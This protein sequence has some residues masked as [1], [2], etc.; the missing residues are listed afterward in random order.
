MFL[1]A[2]A[3][4]ARSAVRSACTVCEASMD[5][6]SASASWRRVASPARLSAEA[7]W[8]RAS[9]YWLWRS[10]CCA[11]SI[12]CRKRG[13]HAGSVGA[14]AGGRTP[15]GVA[16]LPGLVFGGGSGFGLAGVAVE[17]LAGGAVA[18]AGR[19][20]SGGFGRA[21]FARRACSSRDRC[22]LDVASAYCLSS[23][24]VTSLSLRARSRKS[25]ACR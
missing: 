12:A 14:G 24:D 17:L 8:P 6:R 4:R 15:V 9:V 3:A 2:I 16:A 10:A 7:R 1:P 18:T 5:R 13:S 23:D 21:A 19:V 20:T 11:A 22:R 25:W